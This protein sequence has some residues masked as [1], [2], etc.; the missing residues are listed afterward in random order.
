ML[1]KPEKFH[2]WKAA[3]SSKYTIHFDI[4]TEWDKITCKN[5]TFY[6]I[7]TVIILRGFE[8]SS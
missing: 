3:I 6:P 4:F 7:K 1:T 2:D 8:Q 5:G